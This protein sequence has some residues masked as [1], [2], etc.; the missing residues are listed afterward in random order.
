MTARSN[1][2]SEHLWGGDRDGA[3]TA[4][5]VEFRPRALKA[6]VIQAVVVAAQPE[7]AR[8]GSDVAGA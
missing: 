1:L 4:G 2:P 7:G 6:V 8:G 5:P 3:L